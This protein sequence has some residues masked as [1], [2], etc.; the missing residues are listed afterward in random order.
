MGNKEE[1]IF[2]SEEWANAAMHLAMAAQMMGEI[3]YRA[4]HE[5][6]GKEDKEEFLTEMAMA[7]IAMR[8]IA[9]NNVKLIIR[10]PE[11][12]NPQ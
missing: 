4:N 10:M 2:T 6:K 9:D 11:P 3:L 5:G 7:V 1:L 12:K 8:Y